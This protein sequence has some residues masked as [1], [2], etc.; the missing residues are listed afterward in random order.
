VWEMPVRTPADVKARHRF[1]GDL[2]PAWIC[3]TCGVQYPDTDRHPDG[4]PICADERQYVGWNGQQWTTMAEIARDHTVV[5]R[6]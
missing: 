3:V 5:M 1:R 6:N 2:M 4:C